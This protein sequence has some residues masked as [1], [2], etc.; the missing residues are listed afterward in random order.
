MMIVDFQAPPTQ[1]FI[2][3]YS[4][5]DMHAQGELEGEPRT[6]QRGYSLNWYSNHAPYKEFV[7]FIVEK[8]LQYHK[9]SR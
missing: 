5:T 6:V 9:Q 1:L 3:S 4:H 2:T 8:I 7:I